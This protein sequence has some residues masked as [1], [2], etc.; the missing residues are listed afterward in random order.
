M[1][2]ERGH[3]RMSWRMDQRKG[4]RTKILHHDAI[5]ERSDMQVVHR[6][7][8]QR[9]QECGRRVRPVVQ[10]VWPERALLHHGA[11]IHWNTF[12]L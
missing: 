3:A 2:A 10:V 9:V 7:R 1:T 6:A 8:A 4:K 12:Y 11:V 5:L